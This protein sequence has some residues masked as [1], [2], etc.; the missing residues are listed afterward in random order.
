MKRTSLILLAAAIMIGTIASSAYALDKGIGRRV[1]LSQHHR[2]SRDGACSRSC[3][4]RS[5]D[6]RVL[7][8]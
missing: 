5:R 2:H 6:T 3:L 1:L 7:N 4:Q 8:I